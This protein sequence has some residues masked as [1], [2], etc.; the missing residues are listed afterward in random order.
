MIESAGEGLDTV[1]SAND[2]TLLE[3]FEDLALLGTSNI[4]ATGNAV[5]NTLTGNAGNNILDGREGADSMR[6]AGGD[7]IYIVDKDADGI[8]EGSAFSFCSSHGLRTSAS[9]PPAVAE[10]VVSCPAVAMMM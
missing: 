6:G 10:L 1:R 3:N 8:S 5:A 7:D 2:Y 9:R 4:N